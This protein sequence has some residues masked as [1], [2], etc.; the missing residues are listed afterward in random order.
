MNFE[1]EQF[2]TLVIPQGR[3]KG[4]SPDHREWAAPSAGKPLSRDAAL[5]I[6]LVSTRQQRPPL[7]RRL[8]EFQLFPQSLQER[9]EEEY[10]AAVAGDAALDA[11]VLKR[12]IAHLFEVETSDNNRNSKPTAI[13]GPPGVGKTTTVLKLAVQCSAHGQKVG[14]I[15]IDSRRRGGPAY[16]QAAAT[17]FDLNV[18]VATSFRLL[19]QKLDEWSERKVIIDTYGCSLY[20]QASRDELGETLDC[21]FNLER[22]LLLPATIPAGQAAQLLEF[23]GQL[24]PT[25][26]TLSKLDEA[27]IVGPAIQTLAQSPYAVRNFTTGQSIPE[28][29]EAASASKLVELMLDRLRRQKK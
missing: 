23:Y 27:S 4:F 22:E 1:H 9:I 12:V 21:G 28:D 24:S 14:V 7:V 5:D 25:A 16:L 6:S 20:D 17:E 29:L 11:T 3:V 19:V 8:L 13:I 26:L 10:L 18:F 15:T 2:E